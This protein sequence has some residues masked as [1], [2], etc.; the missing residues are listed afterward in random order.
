MFL[1]CLPK[2]AQLQ[3]L[4]ILQQRV[5]KQHAN[6]VDFLATDEA[7]ELFKDDEAEM[8]GFIGDVKKKN[9]ILEPFIQSLAELGKKVHVPKKSVAGKPSSSAAASSKASK[10]SSSAG[11]GPWKLDESSAR[12]KCPLTAKFFK[13]LSNMRWLIVSCGATRSRSFQL[14][15]EELS[16]KLCLKCAWKRHQAMTGEKCLVEGIMDC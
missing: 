16:L 12:A 10:S 5:L 2:L 14:Y 3:L 11:S 8:T 7:K 4:E 6:I 13:D 15:G 1:W 9:D